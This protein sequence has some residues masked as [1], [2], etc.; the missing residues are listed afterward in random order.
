M[1]RWLLNNLALWQIGVLVIGGVTV[2][3]ATAHRAFRK[4]FNSVV[5]EENREVASKLI[6]VL[7]AMFGLL[8]AFVVVSMN[9]RLQEA[10]ANVQVEAVHLSNMYRD[11]RLF[12]P[13][14]AEAIKDAIRGYVETLVGEEKEAMAQGEM[15]PRSSEDL[16][17][18]F[19]VVQSYTP[20]TKVQE[21]FYGEAVGSLNQLNLAR[22]TRRDDVQT[23][24]PHVLLFLILTGAA[25]LITFLSL[26]S[27]NDSWSQTAMVTAVA[28]IVGVNLF[29]IIQ[30]DHPFSGEVSV[31]LDPFTEGT[32][33]KILDGTAP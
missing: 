29:L 11:S 21:V 1:T 26:F 9:Q 24:L 13:I 22:R 2:V 30:F 10:D 23:S 25:V 16:D 28:L 6:G 31:S 17:R 12:E 5:N 14:Y 27:T 20:E 15:S 4:R 18:L 8:L 33:G 19:E 7:M 3:T 32:L